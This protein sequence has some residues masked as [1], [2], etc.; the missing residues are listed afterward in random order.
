MTSTR[1]SGGEITYTIQH[2][3]YL[4]QCNEVLTKLF[5]SD[6]EINAQPGD[7]GGNLQGVGAV[8]EGVQHLVHAQN[9]GG[10]EKQVA[11]PVPHPAGQL[12]TQHQGAQVQLCRGVHQAATRGRGRRYR[13][14][15]RIHGGRG[16]ENEDKKNKNKNENKKEEE[17]EEEDAKEER[18]LYHCKKHF[19]R[20]Y[21]VLK[22]VITFTEH[23]ATGEAVFANLMGV[24]KKQ[25]VT[26]RKPG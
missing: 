11:R 17:E 26:L 25:E 2:N 7:H 9:T 5:I 10:A 3:T 13:R 21:T 24:H 18:L 19:G 20:Y 15:R 14:R 22:F 16:E 1:D 6:A 12:T 8:L 4:S 23:E